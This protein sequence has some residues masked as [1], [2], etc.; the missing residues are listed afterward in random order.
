MST[1]PILSLLILIPLVGAAVTAMTPGGRP[2]LARRTALGFSLF[3]LGL[4][5]VVCMRFDTGSGA[6][7]FVERLA[8]IPALNVEHFL[9]LDGLSLLLIL[10]TS[11]V[12]PFALAAPIRATDNL[13]TYFALILVLQAMIFGVFLSLNFIQ[14]FLFWE[15]SLVPAFLLIKIWGGPVRTAAAYQFFVY[16]L[17]G[18]IAMLL[19][20]L[21]L[22]LSTGLF[23]FVALAELGR[24]GALAGALAERFPFM[25]NADTLLL[26]VFGGIFLGL[27]VKVPVF[28]FHTWLPE[29]YTQAPT[30]VSMI[31]TGLLSKMG[32]YGFLRILLPIFPGQIHA[33]QT[34]LLTLAVATIVFSA[35]AALAQTDLKR[36]L[37][38]S[39]IN[40]LG[41]CLLG[42]FA[43]MAV[44]DPAADQLVSREA[45]LSGVFLQIFNHGLTAA[46]LFC[47]IGLIEARSGGLREL[48][49]FGGLR[50]VAPVLCGL[51]GISLFSSLGLPGLNGFVGEFLIFN[52]AF[53]L[54]GWAAVLALPG[55]LITAVFLLRILAR[56][57][58]GPLNTDWKAFPDLSTRERMIVAPAVALM[59]VIGI[60]PAPLLNLF[61]QTVIVTLQFLP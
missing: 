45:A 48:G 36:I 23:D 4:T 5:L 61:N 33:M 43:V 25:E 11:I 56:V 53:S 16:T 44:V 49:D 60:F 20:F 22:Y 3:S 40:H 19:G 12:V 39:S 8:W 34:V 17:A 37:A 21:A 58:S 54:A 32:I 55:L 15:L 1:F 30:G 18:S 46:A 28:P 26:I 51:M 6:L 29:A 35:L 42:V 47:F 52:G 27:A 24:D 31:L 7:Q 41:Y 2:K 9:G 50:K 10:L 59:F 57:F 38:Y 13:K 14:W